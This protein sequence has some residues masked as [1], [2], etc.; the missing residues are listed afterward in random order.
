MQDHTD[1]VRPAHHSRQA[2]P[3][4]RQAAA[5]PPASIDPQP[6]GRGGRPHLLRLDGYP[7]GCFTPRGRSAASPHS[8]RLRASFG[9]PT[10]GQAWEELQRRGANIAT[11]PFTGE[12]RTGARFGPTRLERLENDQLIEVKTWSEQRL[13]RCAHRSPHSARR[14]PLRQL[15]RPAINPRHAHLDRARSSHHD[16]RNDPFEEVIS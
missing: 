12:R 8:A 13:R 14:G 11:L 3:C 2:G 6:T 9:E 16:H 10:R 5:S 4:R 1:L 15:P 7:R